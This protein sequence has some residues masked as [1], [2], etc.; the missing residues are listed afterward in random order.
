MSEP[1][2]KI[3]PFALPERYELP[4]RPAGAPPAIQ[5]AHRQTHFLLSSDLALFEQA[6][7]LHLA[8][9]QAVAKQRTPE[10]AALV[11]FRSR[12]FSYLS[13]TCALLTRGS[14]TSGPPLLRAASTTLVVAT[15][16]SGMRMSQPMSGVCLGSAARCTTTSLP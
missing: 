16:L 6:M 10:R 11:G 12:T 3:A 4:G 5:D 1:T 2:P 14:Y 8:A 7:N 15:T 9:V 13:D